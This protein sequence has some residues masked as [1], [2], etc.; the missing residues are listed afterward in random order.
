MSGSDGGAAN[1]ADLRR[2]APLP[3]TADELCDVAH[4]LGVDPKTHLFLGAM[5][6]ETKIRQLSEEG[7]LA[8]YK[9][10]HFATHGAVAGQVSRTSEPGLLLTPPDEASET[11]DG[12]LTA[13]EIAGLKLDAD[14]VILSACNTAAGGAPGAEALS[15]LARAFFYAG[16]R[17]LLA[18]HWEVN[19]NST[20]KLITKAIAELKAD[21]K[22]GR[23]EALRRSML[24][25]IDTGK[26]Y[27][28][29]P[30]FWA[31]FV[32]VGEGGVS[33]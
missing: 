21:P 26:N 7:S 2:W 28:A 31:P 8:K 25:M 17:S 29:H 11:D 33:R 13:S 32:L 15:G 4:D 3:E 12:Y 6:T 27:E 5:A 30:A 19:S 9:I 24:S 16:A 20:V 22:I 14:W 18:S 23:A 10:V 1:V